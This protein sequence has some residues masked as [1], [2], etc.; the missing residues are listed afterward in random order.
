MDK[1]Y[2]FMYD[3]YCPRGGVNDLIEVVYAYS[4]Q[5]AITSAEM[6]F[7]NSVYD[8]WQLTDEEFN[9]MAQGDKE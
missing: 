9:I 5:E 7:K 8:C 2:L 3:Y 1:Y 6:F 4:V